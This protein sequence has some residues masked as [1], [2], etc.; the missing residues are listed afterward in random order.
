M[1][2]FLKCQTWVNTA[3]PIFQ[4][5][6]KVMLKGGHPSKRAQYTHRSSHPDGGAIVMRRPSLSRCSNTYQGRHQTTRRSPGRCSRLLP[7][8][9][10]PDSVHTFSSHH[11]GTL[12]RNRKPHHHNQISLLFLFLK[13]TNCPAASFSNGESSLRGGVY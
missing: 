4:H 6:K 11:R 8:R 7:G 13:V 9:N 3:V 1:K 2:I 10:C 12:R 5:F